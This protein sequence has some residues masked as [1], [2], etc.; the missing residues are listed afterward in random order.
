MNFLE[1]SKYWDAGF[2]FLLLL[3]NLFTAIVYLYA[4]R[5]RPKAIGLFFL[6]VTASAFV[7]HNFIYL[8]M[9]IAAIFQVRL[10][11]PA[12]FRVLYLIH[13]GVGILSIAT[14]I[15]GPILIVKFLLAETADQK[16]I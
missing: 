8:T 12:I 9:Q 13:A 3:V 1:A 2:C 6:A 15:I 4:F 10:L 7:F 11:P 5:K 16:R 14:A